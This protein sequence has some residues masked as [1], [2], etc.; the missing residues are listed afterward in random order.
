MDAGNGFGAAGAEAAGT[1][2]ETSG[3]KGSAQISERSSRRGRG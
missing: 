3:G 1:E 2:P